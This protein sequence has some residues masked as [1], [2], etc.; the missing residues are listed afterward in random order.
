MY[1]PDAIHLAPTLNAILHRHS[2]Y[3]HP[4]RLLLCG[5]CLLPSLLRFCPFEHL[6]QHL[7]HFVDKDKLDA[8]LDRIRDVLVDI[9]FRGGR[10]D[11]F[12]LESQYRTL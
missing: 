12:C 11:E 3:P 1:P 7:S 8:R 10:H 2:L 9:G 4:L 6:V 5:K